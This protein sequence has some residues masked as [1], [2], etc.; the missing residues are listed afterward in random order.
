MTCPSRPSLP[1]LLALA[2]AVTTLAP[3]LA[4]AHHMPRIRTWDL[5]A[6]MTGMALHK[7]AKAAP[8]DT[9]AYGGLGLMARYRINRRW[10]VELAADLLH[11]DLEGGSARDL[12]PATA[13]LTYHLFPHSRIQPYG[14]AGLGIITG[15]W[16]NSE[17]DETIGA[18]TGPMGQIG[19][20]LLIDLHPIRLY[21]DI[22]RA[23]IRPHDD[24]TD[25][26]ATAARSV[27]EGCTDCSEG[28]PGA[29]TGFGEDEAITG[30]VVNAG[31]GVTW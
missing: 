31:L 6:R 28:P 13:S 3:A 25:E 20:G 19:A 23:F 18:S 22:R 24:R 16:Y 7:G 29:L 8:E 4:S 21:F 1:A 15:R 30:T 5:G 17:D 26:L 2:V 11:A 27:G 9:Q 14:V 12:I 10:G